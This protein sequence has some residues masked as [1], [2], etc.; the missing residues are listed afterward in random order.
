MVALH[1]DHHKRQ[2]INHKNEAQSYLQISFPKIIYIYNTI[3]KNVFLK[4]Y[5]ARNKTDNITPGTAIDH[6][7]PCQ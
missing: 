6:R 1:T 7:G 2:K 5:I 4:K 3:I